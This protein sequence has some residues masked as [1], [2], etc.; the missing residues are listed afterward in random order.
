MD[1]SVY[2]SSWL[3][4]GQQSNAGLLGRRTPSARSRCCTSCATFIRHAGSILA[5]SIFP[6]VII[7][8]TARFAA[9]V[10]PSFIASVSAWGTS[11]QLYPNLSLHQP[12]TLSCSPLSTIA[13]Q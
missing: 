2:G 9:T 3:A 7:A 12:G 10:S 8:S 13:F 4:R 5:M 11:C 6:M 1:A